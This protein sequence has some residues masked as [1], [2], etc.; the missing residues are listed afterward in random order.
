MKNF[1]RFVSCLL[2]SGITYFFQNGRFWPFDDAKVIT[3]NQ[4]PLKTADF[5]LGC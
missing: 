1:T 3:E 5:W 4:T 2:F